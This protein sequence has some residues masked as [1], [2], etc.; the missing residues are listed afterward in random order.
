MGF[1]TD[2]LNPLS[3]THVVECRIL[4]DLVSDFSSVRIGS[5]TFSIMV[6]FMQPRTGGMVF[7]HVPRSSESDSALDA[8]HFGV[9]TLTPASDSSFTNSAATPE[10][11]PDLDGTIRY[12]APREAIHLSMDLPMPPSPPATT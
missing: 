1:G 7:A 11:A 3:V 2:S 4:R 5:L 9:H 10:A 6:A 12:R 8:S